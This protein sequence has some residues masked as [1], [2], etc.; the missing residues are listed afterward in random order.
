MR[1]RVWEENEFFLSY[2][3]AYEKSVGCISLSE[4]V[5]DEEN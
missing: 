3:M 4:E 5:R 2:R 1:K